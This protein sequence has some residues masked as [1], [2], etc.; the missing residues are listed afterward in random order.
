MNYPSDSNIKSGTWTARL[1]TIFTT[2][3]SDSPLDITFTVQN[4]S[5]PINSLYLNTPSGERKWFSDNGR[6]WKV[7]VNYVTT[8]GQTKYYSLNYSTS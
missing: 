1:M 4:L 7:T 8:S 2:S 6:Y 3:Y 5:S